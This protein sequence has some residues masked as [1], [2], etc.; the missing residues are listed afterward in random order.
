VRNVV[1]NRDGRDGVLI[2]D[3]ARNIIAPSRYTKRRALPWCCMYSFAMSRDDSCLRAVS[4]QEECA[5]E[6]PSE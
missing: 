4:N 2:S 3:R 5:D 1:S 6:A